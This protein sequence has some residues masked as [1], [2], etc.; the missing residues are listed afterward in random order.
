MPT[1]TLSDK[2]NQLLTTVAMPTNDDWE[3]LL[4]DEREI[5][6]VIEKANAILVRVLEQAKEGAYLVQS[7]IALAIFDSMDKL[8]AEYPDAG[9]TDSEACRTIALFFAL[10]YDPTIYEYLRYGR[11]GL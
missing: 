4:D 5:A 1:L 2:R 3:L 9:L 8:N 6:V 10:N 7:E 11:A